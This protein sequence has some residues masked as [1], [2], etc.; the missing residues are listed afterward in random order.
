M[1]TTNDKF[2]TAWAP[3]VILVDADFLDNVAF[4]F[5]VNFERMLE[6]RLP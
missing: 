4:D 5:T 1:K 6:R 3:N 2:S